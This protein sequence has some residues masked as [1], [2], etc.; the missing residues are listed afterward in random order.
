MSKSLEA[1]KKIWHYAIQEHNN[2]FIND[3][4]DNCYMPIKQ[5]L[6]LLGSLKQIWN[7]QEFC[8]GIPLSADGLNSL[9]NYNLDMF[10]KNLELDKKVLDLEKENQEL[11]TTLLEYKAQENLYWTIAT[12]NANLREENEKLKK[13]VEILKDKL[14]LSLNDNK[15]TKTI[16]AVLPIGNNDMNRLTQQEYELISE[17]LE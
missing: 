16:N 17:V 3:V 12:N 15:A 10:N 2:L 1:L 11:K 9:F 13:A 7:N 14:K 8:K 6:E 5:D 4:F